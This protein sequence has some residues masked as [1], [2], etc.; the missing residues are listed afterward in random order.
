MRH[1]VSAG[2]VALRKRGAATRTRARARACAACAAAKASGL[3]AARAAREA[4]LRSRFSSCFAFRSVSPAPPTQHA[5]LHSARSTTRAARVASEALRERRAERFAPAPPAACGVARACALRRRVRAA[6]TLLVEVRLVLAARE[7]VLARHARCSGARRSTK[8]ARFFA[9]RQLSSLAPPPLPRLAV[10][11]PCRVLCACAL[12]RRWRRCVRALQQAEACAAPHARP[13]APRAPPRSAPRALRRR[14][15]LAR[16]RP[17]RRQCCRAVR[18]S[19]ALR[20]PPRSPPCP[21]S[22]H[23]RR[24]TAS[25]STSSSPGAQRRALLCAAAP[26]RRCC[27]RTHAR[28][29]L[30]CISAA[31]QLQHRHW[32][33]R[34]WQARG[35]RLH[36]DN[37]ARAR[38]GRCSLLCA[39]RRADASAAPGLPYAGESRGGRRGAARGC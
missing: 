22:P 38:S 1:A 20:P 31:P 5:A 8:G 7:V 37:G 32:L 26:L 36:R 15:A 17:R 13:C 6:R 25:G 34:R 11:A 4:F 12:R 28:S 27:T 24:R 21:R 14:V 39:V 9:L 2:S 19:L 29:T 30:T 10:R 23:R 3:G 18:Y 16:S 35:A 33:R